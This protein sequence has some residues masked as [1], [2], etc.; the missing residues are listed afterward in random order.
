MT[1]APAR[2][3]VGPLSASEGARL[4]W[5]RPVS[6]PAGRP[7]VAIRP[8]RAGC[9]RAAQVTVGLSWMSRPSRGTGPGH[10]TVAPG[11]THGLD[12]GATCT[13]L[14]PD[15]RDG[16]T[17]L[18][19]ATCVQNACKRFSTKRRLADSP[20]RGDGADLGEHHQ[21]RSDNTGHH[22]PGSPLNLRVRG[23]SPWRRTIPDL[24]LCTFWP[25][26]GTH[27]A[28]PKRANA[29]KKRARLARISPS[30]R[31][32]LVPSQASA[33][34]NAAAPANR[35]RRR[36]VV[37]HQQT[38]RADGGSHQRTPATMLDLKM[39]DPAAVRERRASRVC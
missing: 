4:P 34:Q 39:A 21:L 31:N 5:R 33:G 19:S 14:A 12:C 36:A 15:Q 22:G 30:T 1:K 13:T 10:R 28:G 25:I 29:C 2:R 11:A 38:S 8:G 18:A 9:R 17:G 37:E 27:G 24:A 3:Q 23:S 7:T 32:L 35:S 16:T 20:T 26:C 6:A